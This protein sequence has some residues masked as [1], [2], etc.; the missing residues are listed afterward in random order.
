MS[1]IFANSW[2]SNVP[3][4]PSYP[5]GYPHLSASIPQTHYPLDSVYDNRY[6]K[7]VRNPKYRW[8]GNMEYPYFVQRHRQPKVFTEPKPKYTIH[9]GYYYSVNSYPPY[10]YWYPNPMKCRDA[11]GEKVCN[12]YFR[13][14]NN[15]NNCKRCQLSR[16]YNGLP[17]CF[18]PKSQQCVECTPEQALENCEDRF[19]CANPQGWP[20]ARVPP[21]NPLYT[22]CKNC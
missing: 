20:H 7:D 5:Y 15:Y 2:Y 16:G 6:Q 19:G 11:C 9:N 17:M 13:R 10:T 14:L 4:S 3:R 18:D 22:G 12:E 1:S 8:F 21:Q